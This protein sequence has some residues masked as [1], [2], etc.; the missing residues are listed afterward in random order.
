MTELTEKQK[1][2]QQEKAYHKLFG[3]IADYCV[4]HNINLKMAMEKIEKYEPAVTPEFVKSSWRSILYAQTGK[5]STT[6]QTKEDVKNVQRDFAEL[7]REI[8]CE[9]INWPSVENQHLSDLD[10]EQYQ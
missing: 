1:S 2:R 6:E 5:K 8:T 10:N 9:T 3:Q 4:E 7:W